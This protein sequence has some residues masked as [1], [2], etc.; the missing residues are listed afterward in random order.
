M[1]VKD[2]FGLCS[3]NDIIRE[4]IILDYEDGEDIVNQFIKHKNNKH[5]NKACEIAKYKKNYRYFINS[6]VKNIVPFPNPNK[7]M[8]GVY[9][10]NS[11]SDVFQSELDVELYDCEEL[12]KRF[13]VDPFIEDLKK[14]SNLSPEDFEKANKLLYGRYDENNNNV[15][16]LLPA[17]YSYELTEWEEI[18]GYTV[19]ENNV[20]D[21]GV[22]KFLAFVLSEMTFF[23]F[24]RDKAE[25]INAELDKASKE[26]ERI[27]KLPK[28]EQE[29]YFKPVDFDEIRE[30][31]GLRKNTPEED[32]FE[33]TIHNIESLYNGLQKYRVLRDTWFAE[34]MMHLG[35]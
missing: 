34:Y 10:Y 17:S 9:L 4:L 6:V 21:V 32:D 14:L 28:E 13:K 15:D 18:L 23:G 5:Y 3:I 20:K 26:I 29:N 33:L 30:S 22:A 2:L 7:I 8:I 1:I 16:N 19:Y 31:F 11:L 12:Q 27:S 24:T 35:N 25:E